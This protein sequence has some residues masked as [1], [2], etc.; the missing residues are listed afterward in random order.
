MTRKT[1]LMPLFA[2]SATMLA[3]GVAACF[4]D[5]RDG[6]EVTVIDT[7]QV[8][9]LSS[10]P[11]SPEASLRTYLESADLLSKRAAQAE[12]ELTE[13]CNALDTELGLPTG[14]DS[15]TA[16]RPI[17][18]KFEAII[19]GG[20][21]PFGGGAP[22]W[23]ELRTAA[24]CTVE[25]GALEKCISACAGPCDS[26]KCAAGKVAGKCDGKC[27]GDC[28]TAG[29]EVP[30]NGKCVGEIPLKMAP[31]TCVG[32]CTGICPNGVWAGSCE[33]S[34]STFFIGNCGGTC[35]GQCNGQPINVQ[36]AADAGAADAGG[37]AAGDGGDGGAAPPAPTGGPPPSNAD[38]NCKGTC[39]GVCSSKSNGFCNGAPCL[40]FNPAGPPDIGAYN[41]Y[42][43]GTCGGSCKSATG[44]G[45]TATCKGEC[46][47]RK[48]A[49]TGVCHGTCEGTVSNG[50]CEGALQC[51]Q[52]AECENAC[53]AKVA[54]SKTCSDSKAIEAYA[55]SDEVLHAAL[56]KHGPKLGKALASL[57]ILRTAIS[58]ISKR[59]YGDFVAI[60]LKGDLAKACVAKGNQDVAA[61]EAKFATVASANPTVRKTK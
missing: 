11:K 13:A 30:C 22:E 10:D 36:P 35:T 39:V 60:G 25:T 2:G 49:C 48:E 61:A 33:A 27:K 24:N 57:Q 38:G 19:K 50:T 1:I 31:E 58:F 47:E 37:D 26:S 46:T 44:S 59:A 6:E 16:C 23:A 32:E 8:D 14:Q 53:Q 51:G 41:G 28:V 17:S 15:V 7:C 54:L 5:P 9:K 20:T 12:T 21:T 56:V 18:T 3:I 55:V 34:C 43:P 29:D 52:N 42:C 4:S 40:K 45:A